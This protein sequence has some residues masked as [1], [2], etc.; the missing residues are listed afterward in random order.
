M[1][2]RRMN[3]ERWHGIE[4]VYNAALERGG[5]R[6]DAWFD[7]AHAGEGSQREEVHS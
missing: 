7:E 5:D 6:R 1:E 3:A 2:Q 4:Q